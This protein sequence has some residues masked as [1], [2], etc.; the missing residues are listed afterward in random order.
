MTET[1]RAYFVNDSMLQKKEN[2]IFAIIMKK[3]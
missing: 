2:I 3:R 1:D